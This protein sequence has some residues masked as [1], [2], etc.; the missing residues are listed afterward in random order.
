MAVKVLIASPLRRL[1]G[2]RAEIELE[3][4]TVREV[5]RSLEKEAPGFRN[6]LLDADG[7]VRRF[8]AVFVNGEDIRKSGGAGMAVSDGDELA[9]VPAAAGG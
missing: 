1:A 2:D 8:L 7:E 3:G 6:R 5:I 4:N 9:L